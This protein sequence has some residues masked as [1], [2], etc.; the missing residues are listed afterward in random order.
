[1]QQKK[2][3]DKMD[4]EEEVELTAPLWKKILE[5]VRTIH[6]MTKFSGS[7]FQQIR[8]ENGL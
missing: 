6:P 8:G 2:N 4:D 3:K 7:I 5:Y 1:M